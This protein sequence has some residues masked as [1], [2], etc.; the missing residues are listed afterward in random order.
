M[1]SM[2]QEII[3]AGFGGQGVIL[4]GKMLIHACMV[5]DRHVS[6]IPSYG[7]EMRGGTASCSVVVSSRPIGSP[8]VARPT[9]AILMNRPSCDRYEPELAA[10]GALVYN[11]SQVENEPKRGDVEVLG[12]PCDELARENGSPMSA[13]VAA[14]GALLAATGICEPE[15]MRAAFEVAFARK[16]KE[17]VDLN[18]RILEAAINLVNGS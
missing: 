13:N 18:M 12:L 1:G 4:A 5:E 9:S 6:H 17:A 8:L 15:S 7:I 3:I 14:L 16:G 10:G 2:H 11:S